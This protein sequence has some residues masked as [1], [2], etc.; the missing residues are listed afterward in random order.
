MPT[1]TEQINVEPAL[2]AQPW[3][4]QMI[5]ALVVYCVTCDA[6]QTYLFRLGRAI[7]QSDA[8]RAAR[9]AGWTKPKAGWCCPDCSRTRKE[10]GRD[11]TASKPDHE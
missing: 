5:K 4:G 3:R 11:G 1:L 7:A 8:A 2:P 10:R 9:Q 6:N